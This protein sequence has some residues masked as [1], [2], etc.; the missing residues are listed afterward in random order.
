MNSNNPTCMDWLIEIVIN[1][2]SSYTYPNYNP[3]G[4]KP[5]Y[6]PQGKFP[7]VYKEKENKNT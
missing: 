5:D 7:Y 2:P 6:N 3:T 4:D 1:N